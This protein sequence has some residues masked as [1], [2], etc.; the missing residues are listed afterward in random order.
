MTST[1]STHEIRSDADLAVAAAAGDRAALAGIYHR[2]APRLESYCVGMLRDR[3]AAADCVQD[4]FCIAAVELPKLREPDKLRP[5][6]YA[7]ARR[8]ALR[9]ISERRRETSSDELPDVVA[10]GPGPFTVTAQNELSLLVAEAAA[11]LS[12][13]DR[14]VLDLAYRQALAGAELAEALGVSHESAKKLVQR[15]RATVER[16]LSALLVARYA[17][18]NGC[19][20]LAA[21]LATA[22]GQFSVLMR[23][24]VARHIDACPTCD[25]HR[26]T[27]VSSVAMLGGAI[28]ERISATTDPGTSASRRTTA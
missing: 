20:E 4:V 22:D 6:L 17:E 7:I 24:R 16:S 14:R 8:T 3:H 2:Y 18:Q 9:A 10:Q 28:I 25:A 23:K 27:L 12:E 1:L 11:G 15:L 5:W 26:R 13:R 21:T 19:R